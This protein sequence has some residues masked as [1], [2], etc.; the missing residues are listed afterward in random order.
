MALQIWLPLD[1]TLENKGCLNIGTTNTSAVFTDSGK[2]GQVAENGRFTITCPKIVNILNSVFTISFWGQLKAIPEGS[3]ENATYFFKCGV[4]GTRTCLHFAVRQTSGALGFCFYS[5]DYMFVSNSSSYVGVWHHFTLIFDGE[6]QI[7]YVDGNLIGRRKTGGSLQI[8][9]NSNFI[10]IN[11]MFAVNDFRLYD[12]CLSVA[13][14]KELSQGLIL[15]YKLNESYQAINKNMLMDYP[16][17]YTPTSYR[18]YQLN[19]TEN[20]VADQTYT[21]QFWDIDVSH[22]GKTASDL[23]I[24][25]YW[26]GGSV[27]I[28][29]FNGTDYFTD[30]HADHLAYTFTVTSSQASGSGSANAWFDIYNSVYDATGTKNMHIGKWKLEKGS[31]ATDYIECDLS[32]KANN[33]FVVTDSSGYGHHGQIVNTVSYTNDSRRYSSSIDLANTVSSY[34]TGSCYASDTITFS[35][36]VK[37]NTMK[38]AHVID[39]RTSTEGYQ[40]FYT[41]ANGTVQSGGSNSYV[42]FSSSFQI[43][44]WYHVVFSYDSSALKMY[45][46]GVNIGSSGKGSAFNKVLPFY[47]GTRFNQ[48]NYSDVYISDFRIYCTALSAEDIL[49]L[50]HTSAKIDKTGKVHTFEFVEDEGTKITKTGITEWVEL[51]EETGNAKFNSQYIS[52]NDF[53]ER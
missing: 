26:G 5:D 32:N 19:M 33:P 40:P 30:G 1:G 25:A 3:S 16:K 52:A 31:T 27:V 20:L 9:E 51:I 38:N 7:V 4:N 24:S 8:A 10:I 36:W 49:D 50:Y 6:Y 18:A 17:T 42:S 46:D 34:I 12:H 43:D 48:A 28:K 23:G 53:I 21:L 45:V 15:H 47:L 44:R 29:H 41:Y 35:L 13:E 39:M 14:V 37:F 22:T 11:S 2:I